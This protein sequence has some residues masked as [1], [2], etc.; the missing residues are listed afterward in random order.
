MDAVVYL[1]QFFLLKP[2]IARRH[3]QSLRRVFG[4]VSEILFFDVMLPGHSVCGQDT[5]GFGILVL[6]M[7]TNVQNVS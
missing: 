5:F 6:C 2:T 1:L 3:S 4:F 7:L